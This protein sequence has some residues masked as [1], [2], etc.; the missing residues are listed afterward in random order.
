M[1]KTAAERR[2]KAWKVLIKELGAAEATLFFLD[3]SE[4]EGDYSKIRKE[5]FKDLS[6]EEVKRF[7]QDEKKI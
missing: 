7:K 2:R 1:L 4:G 5:L 6:I 3:I